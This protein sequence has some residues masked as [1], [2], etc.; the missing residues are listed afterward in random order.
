MDD[1]M[2]ILLQKG[3]NIVVAINRELEDCTISECAMIYLL[4]AKLLENTANSIIKM[5]FSTKDE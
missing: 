2:N 5:T 3:D 4:L 1:N